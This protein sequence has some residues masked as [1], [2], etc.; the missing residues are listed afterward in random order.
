MAAGPTRFTE[1]SLPHK[2]KTNIPCARN[3]FY[4]SNLYRLGASLENT[5]LD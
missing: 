2:P 3:S 4:S 1:Y 5:V